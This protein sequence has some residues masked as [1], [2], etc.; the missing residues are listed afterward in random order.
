MDSHMVERETY[1]ASYPVLQDYTARGS[2]EKNELNANEG[3]D[4][5]KVCQ[6]CYK[7]DWVSGPTVNSMS[8]RP[9]EMD[10][11]RTFHLPC[12]CDYHGE[13]L[14]Q[15]E[16]LCSFC[17]HLRLQHLVFCPK[18][19][20]ETVKIE[21]P[22][23]TEMRSNHCPLCYLIEKAVTQQAM[24]FGISE[25]DILD[26]WIHLD[27]TRALEPTGSNVV[28][29]TQPEKLIA[30]F[31]FPSLGD[32]RALGSGTGHNHA[33]IDLRIV[34]HSSWAR[35]QLSE[36]DVS[37]FPGV[38]GPMI[39]WGI[40]R[41]W[42]QECEASHDIR[43]EFSSSLPVGFRVIDVKRRRIIRAPRV[44]KFT[45]LSY[46]WGSQP[47]PRKLLAT[48]NTIQM[49]G[50]DGAIQDSKLPATIADALAV[51]L[52][53]GEDYLWVDRLCIVQDD[54]DHKM[55]Q[56][57]AMND[58]YASASIV[59]IQAYGT[60]MES[61]LPGVNIPRRP[62]QV[63]INI[64]G[65]RLT[66][67]LP[68]TTNFSYK[69]SWSTRGWT[70]QEAALARRKLVMTSFEVI[71]D[72]DV[73][74]NWEDGYGDNRLV[75]SE[76]YHFGDTMLRDGT[77]FDD[78]T[79]HLENYTSRNLSFQSDIYNAFGAI[80][81][82]LY[83]DNLGL[84]HGLPRKDFDQA[85]LWI[86]CHWRTPGAL[87]AIRRVD[88]MSL[89]TW[90]WSS[91]L[92]SAGQGS[93]GAFIG[94][95]VLWHELSNKGEPFLLEPILADETPWHWEND[96]GG[97]SQKLQPPQLYLAHAWNQDCDIEDDLPGSRLGDSFS[98][99]GQ[100]L[101]TRWPRYQDYWK[102]MVFSQHLGHV[103]L[104]QDQQQFREGMIICKAQSAFFGV[105]LARE[106]VY[107]IVGPNG[108]V[109]IVRAD[110]PRARELFVSRT[111]TDDVYE[112][113]GLSISVDTNGQILDVDSAFQTEYD[114]L[115]AA[116]HGGETP[117]KSVLERRDFDITYFDSAGRMLKSPPIV[118]VMLIGIRDGCCYRISTVR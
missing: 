86:C 24:L 55:I 42:T 45:A 63:Q 118:N 3:L 62:D 102:E 104:S 54:I 16:S 58:I 81:N 52:H 27:S 105:E 46:V 112:F 100:K 109:G 59:I 18:M 77:R 37:N 28:N 94:T 113:V 91:F 12:S 115:F 76:Q 67:I 93:Q 66:N 83:R 101:T 85:L 78:F 89:P 11:L 53:L 30:Q 97:P 13:F 64:F 19:H 5:I 72:C 71:F 1:A 61:H 29:T 6:F 75:K 34:D 49:L 36:A 110:E 33:E 106:G 80:M 114:D 44:C 41:G 90:S 69:S 15:T 21:L 32:E 10:Q 31:I 84:K 17:R 35:L 88:S 73:Q 111:S 70:Y 108:G 2:L 23:I 43:D 25:V 116:G 87:P 48:K 9:S 117:Y 98:D 47:D 99:I 56:I 8:P 14:D 92:G 22:S 82:A 79:R 57:Q 51:C 20:L 39:D 7:M 26:L 4:D 96:W 38:R 103:E 107:R 74:V 95:L 60:D 68:K 40:V 65:L 50:E